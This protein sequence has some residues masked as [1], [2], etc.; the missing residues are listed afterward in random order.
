MLFMM[1]TTT[2][3]TVQGLVLSFHISSNGNFRRK[4]NSAYLFDNFNIAAVL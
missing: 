1:T 2:T 3:T 4:K